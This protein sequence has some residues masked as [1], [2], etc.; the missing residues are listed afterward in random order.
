MDGGT[1]TVSKL[2]ALMVTRRLQAAC[3]DAKVL[4]KSQTGFRSGEGCAGQVAALVEACQRRAVADR[5]T[6][7]LFVDFAK[8][9]DSVPRATTVCW[10]SC[11]RWACGDACSAT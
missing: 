7:L 4:P 10:R 6:W 8:A 3:E 9:Y 5:A 2:V 1:T 11:V